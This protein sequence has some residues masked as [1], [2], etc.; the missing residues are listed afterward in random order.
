[1]FSQQRSESEDEFSGRLRWIFFHQNS[2][3]LLNQWVP[4][5]A[6]TQMSSATCW[7]FVTCWDHVLVLSTCR[8]A[9]HR[10]CRLCSDQCPTSIGPPSPADRPS[11]NARVAPTTSDQCVSAVTVRRVKAHWSADG[12][13]GRH[14]C[15]KMR[16]RALCCV[17]LPCVSRCVTGSGSVCC[18]PRRLVG[19]TAILTPFSNHFH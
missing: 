4:F 3:I 16:A 19:L 15:Q 9:H 13:A 11:K 6:P 10:I 5:S 2:E 18:A 7:R 17:A 12:S 1:M 8:S 14:S